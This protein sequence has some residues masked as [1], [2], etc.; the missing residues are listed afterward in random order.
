MES[1]SQ[2]TSTDR[3]A[4]ELACWA[5]S[6]AMIIDHMTRWPSTGA[7]ELNAPD[8]LRGLIRETLAPIAERHAA[9]DLA[10]AAEVL[11]DAVETLGSE[12]LLVDPSVL[13]E[14][15]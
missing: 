1:D 7:A 11:A 2:M 4:E 3:I 9:G 10:V 6:G 15:P 12:I 14:D 13:D 8:T 5:G